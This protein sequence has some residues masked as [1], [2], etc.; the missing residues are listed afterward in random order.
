V[1][2]N[3]EFSADFRHEQNF[4]IKHRK[5]VRQKNLFSQELGGFFKEKV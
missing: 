4:R 5:R 3:P 2:K 1:S